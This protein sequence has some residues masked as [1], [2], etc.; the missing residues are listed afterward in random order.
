MLAVASRLRWTAPLGAI[1]ALLLA[2]TTPGSTSATEPL[3]LTHLEV[4]AHA[5]ADAEALSRQLD[6]AV[7]AIGGCLQHLDA[8]AAAAPHTATL[9]L[10]VAATGEVVSAHMVNP[11]ADLT[12]PDARTCVKEVLSVLRLA[13]KE[14]AQNVF[15]ELRYAPKPGE[16]TR[17]TGRL[18]RADVHA[19][20]S[21]NIGLLAP[22]QGTQMLGALIGQDPPPG[23]TEA[24]GESS[25]SIRERGLTPSAARVTDGPAS[26]PP[27]ARARVTFGDLKVEGM[28]DAKLATRAVVRQRH[29]VQMCWEQAH[30]AAPARDA[31]DLQLQLTVSTEGRVANASASVQGSPMPSVSTCITE[32][33]KRWR[34]P[35]PESGVAVVIVPLV[36]R[37][38]AD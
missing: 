15:I 18:S 36:L 14:G 12:Q 11:D 32:R 27:A 34:F 30:R 21:S 10:R 5:S 6:G 1:C 38:E 20:V 29:A 22:V 7:D 8:E 24:L 25:P 3:S 37:V 28:L 19:T 16:L 35:A 26:H 9:R 13:P 17:V 23:L 4:R 33:A 2:A 31:V